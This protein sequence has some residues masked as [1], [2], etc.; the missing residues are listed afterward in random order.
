M[1]D[2]PARISGHGEGFPTYKA[3]KDAGTEKLL[4]RFPAL[5]PEHPRSVND[6]LI[7]MRAQVE[8]HVLQPSL[9]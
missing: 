1:A 8:R 5:R 2:S 3:A 7:A 9:F 4:M 6:E